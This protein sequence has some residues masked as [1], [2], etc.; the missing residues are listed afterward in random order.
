MPHHL[1]QN[2]RGSVN[3]SRL[4]SCENQPE[5]SHYRCRK[6]YPNPN[7]W[8]TVNNDNI[9]T[10]ATEDTRLRIAGPFV[11]KFIIVLSELHLC[12][13]MTA[14]AENLDQYR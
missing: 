4:K 1:R 14:S 13:A 5:S 3:T 8:H 12:T 10:I 6:A 2:V 9:D 11:S 7:P